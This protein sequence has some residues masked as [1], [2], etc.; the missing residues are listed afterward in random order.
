MIGLTKLFIA[1]P[2]FGMLRHNPNAKLTSLPLNQ[3]DM[4]AAY[5][6]FKLSDPMPNIPLPDS[7]T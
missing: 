2:N 4:M 3:L 6:A 1:L 5:A 7:I